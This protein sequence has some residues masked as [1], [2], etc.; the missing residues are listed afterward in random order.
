MV[1]PEQDQ[2]DVTPNG[3][4][5][6]KFAIKLCFKNKFSLLYARNEQE[7]NAWIDAFTQVGIRTDFHNRFQVSRIIGSGAFANVYEATEKSSEKKYAIKGFN[8]QYLEQEAKGKESLWNEISILRKIKHNN[9]LKLHEVH[10]TKNSVYLVFD[11]YRGGELGKLLENKQGLK[12]QEVLNIITGLLRGIDY[13]A[14]K[15]IVHRDLKPNNIIL[16]KNTDIQPEDVVIV[17]FGLAVSVH[18]KNMIFKRCGTPG[19]IA[20]EIIGAKNVD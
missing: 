4:I 6:D 7:F 3:M 12:E 17:D 14:S 16:R 13:L 18:D 5:K 20:P 9:L 10:E 19:Y 15:D 8:K 2:T 11:V 1:L